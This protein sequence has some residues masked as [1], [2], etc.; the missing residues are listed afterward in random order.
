MARRACPLPPAGAASFLRQSRSST[1]CFPLRPS[2][3]RKGNADARAWCASAVEQLIHLLGNSRQHER[4][5]GRGAGVPMPASW[6]PASL[7]AL[8]QNAFGRAPFEGKQVRRGYE[9]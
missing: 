8:T 2:N 6:Y 1:C 5:T 9:E 7:L 4:T 3:N